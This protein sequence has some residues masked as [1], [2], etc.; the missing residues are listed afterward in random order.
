MITQYTP[1]QAG[2][3]LESDLAGEFPLY[4]YWPRDKSTL[5]YSTSI[6]ELLS[7]T[8]V[9]KPLKVCNE[10]LSFLLQS[11]VVPPPKTAYEDIYI[12]GIGDKAQVSTQNEKVQVVFSHHFPFMNANRLPTKAMQ[13]DEDFI[14][15]MLAEATITRLAPSKPSFLFHSAGKDSNSIAL[16]LAEAGWQNRVT[17]IT[18]KSKG[19]V[20][21][22]DI[23]AKIAKKLGFKH[24]ILFEVD[25]LQAEHHLAIESYFI[26]AP[27]PCTDNVTLAYPLYANQ[28]PELKGANIID[29]MGNDV[30][31][32]HIPSR[33]EYKRQQ[34]SK[35]LKFS[36]LLS[37]HF[38]SESL[39]QIAGRTRAEW[40]GLSGLS[41][42]DTKQ[43]LPDAF[44][45]SKYWINKDNNQNYLDFRSSI[46]GVILDQ[47]IFTRKVRNFADS[48]GGIIIL[49]W[50]N[51]QVSGYFAKMPE[52]Y[53]FDRRALKNKL[54]L[55]KILKDR[56]GLDSDAMG[57]LGFSYDSH[58][59]LM[60]NIENMKNE[61]L[62]CP[63]W[64]SAGVN[65][66][67]FRFL[68]QTNSLTRS[69]SIVRNFIYRL[70][71]ISS[72]Y[73]RSRFL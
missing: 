28:L 35:Y 59:V 63:L 6:T 29:G 5:L 65:H 25:Q 16:A 49:P 70:Y 73:N 18:H 33:S 72:W 17:L 57:K 39:F 51:Q 44:D 64:R 21:E 54:I 11:G 9:P 48:V 40:T 1:Q 19:K 31:I 41:Y 4:L 23:S 46:R 42:S 66:V 32:G 43:L 20:D 10:G 2:L 56:I 24:Q 34:I 14:L 27:L 30:Y 62:S 7:D 47:E 38:S 58:G 52:A 15:Q 45:V 68:S 69:G 13:P 37:K 22:S 71:L 12:V 67:L 50:A 36:R 53:L 8:R 60:N 3:L 55:R 26:N 61:I